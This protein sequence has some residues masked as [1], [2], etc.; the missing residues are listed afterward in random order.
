[1]GRRRGKN[2]KGGTKLTSK[3]ESGNGPN[4]VPA[5]AVEGAGESKGWCFGL[6]VIFII[7][8]IGHAGYNIY[9][10]IDEEHTPEEKQKLGLASVINIVLAIL[11]YVYRYSCGPIYAWLIIIIIL[12]IIG[13]GLVLG[14]GV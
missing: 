13:L 4:I 2:N 8:S 12:I 11:V 6:N 3:V 1:M 7:Y 5:T 14:L 10:I 9:S